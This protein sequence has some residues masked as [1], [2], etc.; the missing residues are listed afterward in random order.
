MASNQNTAAFQPETS[1]GL[2]VPGGHAKTRFFRF[3]IWR[4]SVD[5]SVGPKP[6]PYT[7]LTLPTKRKVE[8]PGVAVSC[9][10]TI[11]LTC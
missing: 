7:Q 11:Q 9:R 1:F 4:F 10:H 6:V 3:L 5:I 8:V 2:H